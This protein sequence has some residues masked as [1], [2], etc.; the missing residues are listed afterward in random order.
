MLHLTPQ[1]S[2]YLENIWAWTA[3]HDLDTKAQEQINVYSG[4]GILVESEGP[5]WM[6]GTASEHNLLYQY[7][8]SNAKNLYMS[9]I[10]TESPYF[11]PSPGAPRPFSTGSFP[12]DPDF[13]NC[14]ASA[15]NCAMSWALRIIDSS[16]VYIMG[17]GIFLNPQSFKP[18]S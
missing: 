6:Y 13:A 11:Q 4:R 2:A 9:M 15:V 10:Q 18:Q 1:S 16:S 5:T 17:T 3:D 8:I 12:N 14:N 7:Q